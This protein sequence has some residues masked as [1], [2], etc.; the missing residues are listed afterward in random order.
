MPVK[1]SKRLDSE[2]A[3]RALGV[4]SA[5]AIERLAREDRIARRE[6]YEDSLAAFYRVMFPMMDPAPFIGGWHLDAMADHLQAITRGEITRLLISVPPRFS[7][8]LMVSVAWPAWSWC[9]GETSALAGPHVK[10]IYASYSS[11]FSLRD[12]RKTRRLIDAPLYTDC[13]GDRVQ[14][15]GTDQDAYFELSAG[16]FRFATSVG[17]GVTG[18][19]GDVLVCLPKNAILETDL[20]PD[21]IGE[22][23]AKKEKRQV[24]GFDHQSGRPRWQTIERYESNPR[25]TILRIKIGNRE[26]RCTKDHPI[27]ILGR[28][29][30]PA[31]KVREGEAALCLAPMPH[32]REPV[33]EEVPHLF[34]SV[35]CSAEVSAKPREKHQEVRNMRDANIP[36]T[37]ALGPLGWAPLLQPPLSW[38]GR[39]RCRKPDVGRREADA[40]LC[41]L[42][43]AVQGKQE[44]RETPQ[45]LFTLLSREGYVGRRARSFAHAATSRVS[46]MRGSVSAQNC[47]AAILWQ[48]LCVL[49]TQ[50]AHEGK[51]Q[52]TLCARPGVQG[53]RPRVDCL[54]EEENSGERRLCLPRV[55]G[56]GIGGNLS[57]APHRLRQDEHGRGKSD[58]SVPPMPRGN[59]RIAAEEIGVEV[60]IVR[61]ITAEEAEPTFNVR[62]TPDHNYFANGVLVHNCDDPLSAKKANWESARLEA[63]EW[64]DETMSSR[65]N[66][67][68]TGAKVVIMQRLHQDDLVG[69][70]LDKSPEEW[71]QLVLPMEFDFKRLPTQ[72][73]WEDPREYEGELLWP[74]RFPAEAVD[75]LKTDL[76]PHAAAAQLQQSPTPRGGGIVDRDW[77]R[78]WDREAMSEA[79]H[80]KGMAA[81]G[82]EVLRFPMCELIIASVDT[83]YAQ[84]DEDAWNALTIWGVWNDTR[85]RPNTVMMEAWRGRV[86]LRGFY[87]D[88]GDYVS[89]YQKYV[90]PV[91][92]KRWGLAE[93]IAHRCYKRKVDI[94]LIEDKTKGK[95]LSDEVMRIVPFGEL[96]II[97][98]NPVADK[99]ARLHSTTPVFA[100]GRVWAPDKAWAENVINEVSQ[101]P[102][103]KFADFTDTVSQAISFMRAQGI[104]MLGTEADTEAAEAMRFQPAKPL[105]Y[106][107]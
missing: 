13:W 18:E 41:T 85:N 6:E 77:W 106:D 30:V 107:V 29:Y 14:I 56:A 55:R 34:E 73:G 72:I 24:L 75:R 105:P 87:P 20:G 11:R 2:E 63:N 58:Y 60:A 44:G 70:V 92:M 17:G 62:V 15:G 97:M 37:S 90:P 9:Q 26:L 71:C 100:D 78:T 4:I 66:D 3:K 69:H 5:S 67:P 19:G 22:I 82:D 42:R 12:S 27:F 21:R 103:S 98:C 16:G 52:R 88:K 31:E 28:G 64:W 47:K 36:N 102:K 94:L 54:L 53:L 65:L 39:A 46:R 51:G 93:H 33:F 91:Q 84:K 40:D 38:E 86:P 96:R 76:G 10:F 48:G 95:D 23:V 74:E 43:R 79:Q 49:G 25:R 32:L 80:S 7:K 81:A 45:I 89:P 59:A 104:L 1:R 61:S 57:S 50:R 68:M 99:V 83:A 8:S 35:L 101:F